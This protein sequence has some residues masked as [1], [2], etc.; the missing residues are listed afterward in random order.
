[1]KENRQLGGFLISILVV[2]MIS[3]CFGVFLNVAPPEHYEPKIGLVFPYIGLFI[4][5]IALMKFSSL[6][7]YGL[8]ITQI[9]LAAMFT[10]Y[11]HGKPFNSDPMEFISI[12]STKGFTWLC[13][14]S[15]L[16]L[17]MAVR[18]IGRKLD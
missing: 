13:A 17:W 14:V 6:G 3:G 11:Y 5:S 16:F 8:I 15:I 4:F 18:P 10:F 7:Y 1:M 9:I 12:M 2:Y